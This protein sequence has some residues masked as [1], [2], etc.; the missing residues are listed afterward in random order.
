MTN[1]RNLFLIFLGWGG[2]MSFSATCALASLSYANPFHPEQCDLAVAA[3]ERAL[4]DNQADAR[5]R[6]I[7]AEGLL[8]RGLTQDDP[9]ALEAAMRGFEERLSA[10]ASDFFAQLYLAEA[11]RRRFPLSDDVPVAF[12]RAIAVVAHADVGSAREELS[13]HLRGALGAVRLHREQFL[14]TLQRLQDQ[15]GHGELSWGQLGAFVTLLA[16]TGPSGL[17]RALSELDAQLARHQNPAFDAFYRAELL[18]GTQARAEV[19]ALYRAA[20]E[21]LC[22]PRG[23]S[24]GT[25]CQRARWRIDQLEAAGKPEGG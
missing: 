7:L 4:S 17:R 22:G 12:E 1:A 6:Q 20:A 11:L 3:A 2:A 9:W 18:R 15:R 14:P 8:C 21:G 24:Q 5:A 19:A 23:S 13:I 16:H 25:E 10:D